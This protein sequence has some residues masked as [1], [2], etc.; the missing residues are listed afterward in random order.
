MKKVGLSRRDFIRSSSL[1]A[2]G[3]IAGVLAGRSSAG[4]DSI[5]AV[6][7]RAGNAD[8]DELRL[9]YLKELRKQSGLD[10]SFKNDL[11]KLIIQIERWLGDK[12]LD[13]FGREAGSKKDFDFKI[14][15]NSALYPLTWLYRG[16]MVIWYALESGGVWN[17]P[18]RKRQFFAAARG[19]FEKY[20]EVFP[21]N[22]IV[23]M[24]LGHPTASHKRYETVPGAPPWAVYQREGLERLADV[25]EWW[26]D[27]RMQSDDQYGGGWGDDCE[28]W[29][30][31]VPVLIGFDSPKISRAQARF[32]KAM[33]DQDHMK[34]GYTTR[35]SD[36]EHT[37]EDSADAITPMMHIDPQNDLWREYALGL[38]E[39]MEK[40]WTARNERGFLQFKST[41][42]TADKVDTNP[43]RACDT[44]YHPRVV[45][46]TLLYWQRTGDERLT[47]LFAAWMDTWVDAAARSERGKPAGVIPTA[48]HWPDGRVG[49]LGPDW[50][51][52]RNHG[53]YTLYL[54]PSAMGLM[55]HT[56]LLTHYMTGEAKYLA[57]IR[58]MADIRLKYLSSPHQKE[59]AAGTEA[60]CASRLG[61]L[62][63]VIAKYRFLTGNAE[64]DDFL[65]KDM[66]PY[67]RFRMRGDS[68]PLVL[69]L[70]QNAEA[71]RINFQGYTSE[72]RY[73]DRV[74]RFPS[75]F[76]D[77][78]KLAEPVGTIHTPNPSLL[79]SMATG[80]P[81]DAGYFPLNAVR[82]LTPPRN[83]AVLVTESSSTQFGAELFC[84]D[85]GQ[86]SMSAEFYLLDPGKYKLTVAAKDGDKEKLSQTREFV[87]Q[88][89]RTRVSFYLPPR[90][91]SVLR[92]SPFDL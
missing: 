62:A 18:E 12:R 78:D 53:E 32:S 1:A 25:I 48:I 50:W 16:R 82:W 74:L 55:T 30:W 27:N 5:R 86:R 89:R 14:P 20:A 58:A 84:F 92:I 72:V 57:P 83:I 56:L 9:D 42:F 4:R 69:A 7:Q 60:W 39:F 63:S 65:A 23:R 8:S 38:A 3:T 35:M 79:Y 87:V 10:E 36:V 68:A 17:N 88:G 21:E 19:F 67:M 41:Y 34:R 44:V 70:R 51:D 24:Y 6:I 61:G 81:G 52:P 46:P 22:K 31:W 26:I 28:M 64:F 91:L 85:A 15:E 75:L 45:Q 90:R 59:P 11:A 49:G 37:A 66:S 71:L 40:S 33:M 54:Y 73:T 80:D 2:A 47:R 43:Q 13:Y 29:R 77:G 76:A